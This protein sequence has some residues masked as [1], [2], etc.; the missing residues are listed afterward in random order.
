MKQ[1]DARGLECPK[2]V[3]L[4]K[5][6]LEETNS[7]SILVDNEVARDNVRR[8]GEN[9]G[10][11]VTILENSKGI[12]LFLKKIKGLEK[13]TNNSPVV[14]LIK[15]D[16]FGDGERALG[17]LLM[18][19][20]LTSL[21][22]SDDKIGSLIFMNKGVVLTT[23][24]EDAI[25]ILKDLEAQGTRIFSCGTCLDFYELKD[26][27]KIGEITNMYSATELLLKKNIRTII[28]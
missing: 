23:T 11:D 28:I 26:Q 24:S 15:K 10:F 12:E 17:E 21:L 3:I 6:A 5:K 22:E 1:I 19:N 2:P 13:T 27:L 7:I 14:V 20:F 8:F 18:K 25:P 4:T 16:V 9:G